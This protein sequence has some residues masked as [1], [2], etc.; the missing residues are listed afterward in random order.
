MMYLAV[1]AQPLSQPVNDTSP[2]ILDY[3]QVQVEHFV[4]LSIELWVARAY[5]AVGLEV[6][7]MLNLMINVSRVQLQVFCALLRV[8]MLQVFRLALPAFAS[9]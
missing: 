5:R 2:A 8:T 1:V 7:P 3:R 6:N 4:E 9:T